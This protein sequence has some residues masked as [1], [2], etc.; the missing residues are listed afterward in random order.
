MKQDT[1]KSLVLTTSRFIKQRKYWLNKLAGDI[2]EAKVGLFS[3][4]G[5]PSTGREGIENIITDPISD[6]LIQLSKESDLSVY[7]ILLT[8]LKI[9]LYRYTGSEDITVESPLFKPNISKETL[10]DRLWIRDTIHGEME[11]RDVLFKI[12]QSVLEAYENQDYPLDELV[13]EFNSARGDKGIH[14]FPGVK[15]LLENIHLQE[16]EDP[17]RESLVFSFYRESESWRV[18]GRIFYDPGVFERDEAERLASHFTGILN[19][20]IREVNIKVSA[21]RFL[22]EE[23]KKQLIS[24]FNN[25]S[26][27][28]PRDKCIHELFED[29]VE[30][31]PDRM[32]VVGKE[33][34]TWEP[35]QL[36]YREL[37]KKSD[38]FACLLREK[39]VLVDDI[40]AIKMERSIDMIIGILGILKAG[41]AYLSID[42]GYPAER[43]NYMLKDSNARVLVSE[44]SEGTEVVKLSEMHEEFPTYLTHPTHLTQLN[45][46]YVLYTSGSTGRPKGAMI[47]HYSL[48]NRLYWMQYKYPLDERDV[49]LLKADFAFDVSVMEMF[50]PL[51]RSARLCLL[52][53]GGLKELPVLLK[54]IEKYNVSYMHFVPSLLDRILE[55]LEEFGEMSRVSSLKWITV[56]G[57]P[58]RASTLRKFKRVLYKTKGIT[59][60]NMYGLTEAVID[61]T[62]YDC[63]MESERDRE[64]AKVPIGSPI[65]NIRIYLLDREMNLQP[66]GTPGQLC[67]SG[68]GLARGYINNPELTAEKFDHDLWDFQDY[69]DE[70]NYQKLLRGVQGG[71]FLEKSPS[72]RRRLY[73]TGDLAR[74]LADGN[75]EFLGRQDYQVKVR[76]YRIELGEIENHLLNHEKIKGVVVVF[77]E[78]GAGDPYLCAYFVRSGVKPAPPVQTMVYGQEQ[79]IDAGELKEYLAQSLPG[80]MIPSYFIEIDKIPLTPNG[81]INR[82]ALPEPEIGEEKIYMAPRDEVEKKL[83]RT[84]SEVLGIEERLIGIDSNFFELGGHSLRAISLMSKIQKEFDVLVPFVEFIK[85]PVI[86]ELAKIIKESTKTRFEAI[87]PTEKKEYYELSA[88]QKRLYVL[89][90][91]T[92]V[93]IVYN[94]PKTMELEGDVKRLKL[95]EIFTQLIHRHEGY[96]TSFEMQSGEPVQRIYDRVEFEIEYYLATEAVGDRSPTAEDTEEIGKIHNSKFIIQNSL[97]RPFDLSRAPLLRVGLI[98]IEDGKYVFIVDMHH[99][100]SDGISMDIF[101]KESMALYEGKELAGLKIQYKD[102]AEWQGSERRKQSLEK[103]EGYWL[104]QFKENVPQPGIPTDFPKTGEEGAEGDRVYFEIDIEGTTALKEFSLQEGATLFMMVLAIYSIFLWKIIGCECEDIVVGTAVSGRGHPDLE[105]VIGMFINMLPLRNRL[106]REKTFEKF[107]AEVRENT[108]R[109]FENQDYPFDDLVEKLGV[110]RDI[111]RTPLFDTAFSFNTGSPWEPPVIPDLTLRFHNSQRYTAKFDLVLFAVDTGNTLKL[112]FEYNT[113]LSKKETIQRYTRYFKEIVFILLTHNDIPLEEIKITH[114]LLIPKPADQEISFNF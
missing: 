89:Q 51:I 25:T 18:T 37:N 28:Y 22:S 101:I 70:K 32:A 9:L 93:S 108:V 42:P 102:F 62:N 107:L 12:R 72:G 105:P 81:K 15:C 31:A 29:R 74:W 96:R 91:M 52:E 7:I 85:T 79:E 24:I 38:Q 57:E 2:A 84:W 14:R 97:I 98:K 60:H 75:I 5:R 21:I 1:D 8:A 104:A 95:E 19:H 54:A 46:A 88:A 106:S 111:N 26:R 48:V 10:N 27:D 41:G 99:I 55:Y 83:S 110:E 76:G 35:L 30:R 16:E 90:K 103:Q 47:E 33:E 82:S 65:D 78:T 11:F 40:V 73:K 56:G 71:S 6:R 36:T 100:V 3:E 44:V 86:R 66:V 53:P 63:P 80:Y 92:P 58:L 59:L 61:V 39:G 67:I 64:A 43:I 69:Q 45:M 20:S 17:A 68:D 4:H 49:L 112:A 94:M 34:K 109:A 50:W 87:E 77:R 113:A 114:E 13:K 23:E